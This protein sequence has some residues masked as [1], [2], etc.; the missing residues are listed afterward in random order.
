M[1]IKPERSIYTAND[2]ISF[3]ETGSLELTARF[4]RREVWKTPAKS[5]FIDTLLRG[6]PVPPIYVRVTQSTEHTRTVREIID[7]QQRLRAL[8][9]FVDGKYA[10][11]NAAGDPWRG[12]YFDELPKAQRDAIKEFPF[13]FEVLH[14]ISDERVLEIFSRLNTYSVP[15]NSQELRN[16]TYF[17]LFK[18]T[19]YSLAHEHI[20]FWRSNRIFTEARI[21]R[22]LEVELTSELMILAMAGLQ[23]KKKSINR[24]YADND[25][26]F[27]SQA[28]IGDQFRRV[29]DTVS[30]TLGDNL[31]ESEFRRPPLFYSLYAAVFHIKFGVPN[32]EVKRPSDRKLGGTSRK[33]LRSAITRLSDIIG[34]AKAEE[35]VPRKYERFVSSSLRQTDNILPR[36]TRT[37]TILQAAFD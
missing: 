19:A 20:E 23:D 10:L 28:R 5:F 13:I 7:G 21:A 37:T 1:A 9:D 15:L 24:F 30:E 3:R 8:L 29:L 22:M 27:P 17:G 4:Q 36:K 32:L 26:K 18:Q 14:G 6:Y 33:A 11:T 16:G 25:A 34:L 12:A 2:L 31:G 35:E